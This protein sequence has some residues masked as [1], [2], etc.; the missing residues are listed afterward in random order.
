MLD[1]A[2]HI[3][4]IE[5]LA[6]AQGVEFHKPTKSSPAICELIAT[7]RE[8]S[9]P[10]VEDRPLSA[11]VMRVASLID[12]GAFSKYAASVLPGLDK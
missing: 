3:V 9:P 12:A 5:L 11:D 10:Y 1:N 6:A 8:I 7:L 4:A 2:G